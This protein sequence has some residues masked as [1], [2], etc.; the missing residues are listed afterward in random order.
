MI[1]QI[2]S[3]EGIWEETHYTCF[4]GLK[5]ER[6]SEDGDFHFG[7]LYPWS[8][9]MTMYQVCIWS[10]IHFCPVAQYY[11]STIIIALSCGGPARCVRPP[12]VTGSLQPFD[13][14]LWVKC[15]F[16]NVLP[17]ISV[18]LDKVSCPFSQVHF[19]FPHSHYI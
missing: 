8:F 11:N 1:C 6:E 7:Y 19:N 12:P 5:Q 14:A 16:Q 10:Q 4:Q 2:I 15:S 17:S 13:I 9:S 18:Y 3:W